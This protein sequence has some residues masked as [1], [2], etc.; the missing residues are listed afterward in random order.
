M[1]RKAADILEKEKETFGRADDHGDGQD[2]SS[3]VDEAA[4]CAWACRYYAEN[5]ERFLADEVVETGAKTQLHPLSAARTG[6]GGDA[7]EFSLLAGV[8]LRRA[9]ADG[10][11]RRAAQACLQRAAVRAGDRGHRSA[12]PA[13]RKACFRRC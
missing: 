2:A 6:A 12:A 13:S 8:P 7:V 10:G 5:A 1:M 9:G 3:A 4:K 11:Q